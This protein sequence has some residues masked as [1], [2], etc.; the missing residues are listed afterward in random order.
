MPLVLARHGESV[1]NVTRKIS[2]CGFKHGLTNPTDTPI[3]IG[4]PA[5]MV[6]HRLHQDDDKIGVV[7]Y[8][9]KI[10]PVLAGPSS[11]SD[12]V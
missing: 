3:E 2:N 9:K 5:E 1:A 10:M 4:I 12:N 11:F 6:T 7:V 8:D